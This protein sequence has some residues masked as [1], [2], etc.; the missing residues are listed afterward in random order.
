M[1]YY[2]V[3]I[4]LCAPRAVCGIMIV[5]YKR[6][7]NH[8]KF[9]MQPGELA[10]SASCII[11]ITPPPLDFSL[12][13]RYASQAKQKTQRASATEQLGDGDEDLKLMFVDFE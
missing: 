7:K 4:E 3:Y 2:G 1:S 10:R 8:I 13:L 5:K 6:D 12:Q 9:K 11:F